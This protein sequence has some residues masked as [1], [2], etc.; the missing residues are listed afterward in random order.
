MVSKRGFFVAALCGAFV[1]GPA[2]AAVLLDFQLVG[3]D[4]VGTL[5]GSLDLTGATGVSLGVPGS[6]DTGSGVVANVA[7]VGMSGTADTGVS[8]SLDI[9]NTTS[10]PT[11]FGSSNGFFATG[12]SGDVFSVDGASGVIGV[13]QGYTSGTSLSGTMTVHGSSPI[14]SF[15]S[16]GINEGT[17]VYTLPNDTVTVQFGSVSPVPLPATGPMLLGGLTGLFGLGRYRKRRAAA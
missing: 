6:G 2:G 13:A 4:L 5:S 8:A 12:D 11:S 7:G 3:G 17:Y 16:I 1:A 10:G 15:A 14:T 9:W